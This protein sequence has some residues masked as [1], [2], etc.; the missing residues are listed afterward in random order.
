M[1]YYYFQIWLTLCSIIAERH[2]LSGAAR[3]DLH[4]LHVGPTARADGPQDIAY[5][6]Q[7]LLSRLDTPEYDRLHYCE[8]CGSVYQAIHVQRLREQAADSIA[9]CTFIALPNATRVSGRQPCGQPLESVSIGRPHGREETVIKPLKTISLMDVGLWLYRTCSFWSSDSELFTYIATRTA[10]PEG[11]LS[12]I[13]DGE[14]WNP[15]TEQYCT[16]SS[17]YYIYLHLAFDFVS[18]FAKDHRSNAETKEKKIG[19]LHFS[20]LNLP[21]HMRNTGRNICTAVV[22]EDEPPLTTNGV[23]AFIVKTLLSLYT[24]GMTVCTANNQS[25]FMRV[26]LYVMTADS[27]ARSKG[28]GCPHFCGEWPC[29]ICFAVGDII[30]S[31]NPGPPHRNYR[32]FRSFPER[33]H[34]AT[35]DVLEQVDD[36][37]TKTQHTNATS[38]EAKGVRWTPFL[39]LPYFHQKTSIAYD[40][41]HAWVEGLLKAKLRDLI[42]IYGDA[43]VASASAFVDRVKY[44]SG[45]PSKIRSALPRN[46]LE[47][48]DYAKAHEIL[49]FVNFLSEDCFKPLV[50][51]R[52]LV[53][54]T[55]LV[56]CSRFI[57]GYRVRKAD[58]PLYDAVYRTAMVLFQ[59]EDPA[60]ITLKSNAH[61]S[62][63]L[64]DAIRLFGPS[65]TVWCFFNERLM[66]RVRELNFSS[67]RNGLAVTVSNAFR[68]SMFS[69]S[70]LRYACAKDSGCR[71]APG[72][73]AKAQDLLSDIADRGPWDAP[74]VLQDAIYTASRFNYCRRTVGLQSEDVEHPLAAPVLDGRPSALF[75]V[76][77]PSG[78]HAPGTWQSKLASFLAD[79]NMLDTVA[80]TARCYQTAKFG[81]AGGMPLKAPSNTWNLSSSARDPN[82]C[83]ADAPVNGSVVEVFFPVKSAGGDGQVEPRAYYGQVLAFAEFSFT[84]TAD[85]LRLAFIKWRKPV[86]SPAALAGR[87]TSKLVSKETGRMLPPGQTS[88]KW[89]SPVVQ[90]VSATQC[91][92]TDEW[93]PMNRIASTVALLQLYNASGQPVNSKRV[94]RIPFA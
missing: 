29:F 52:H 81:P 5:E 7:A 55:M 46:M 35:L 8:T 26:V 17:A 32:D 50:S 48:I 11:L 45:L 78:G 93:I 53:C 6:H 4:V 2:H 65:F 70:I 61:F 9:K 62:T 1:H 94:I 68:Q 69:L 66:G 25:K 60:E 92:A 27:P 83:R 91:Y 36:A 90:L 39:Q 3:R 63:H 82:N 59:Q 56:E 42:A 37:T 89:T 15:F 77:D 86:K 34:A 80:R 67:S 28:F 73:L 57:A 84:G 31:V 12:D 40:P 19:L 10:P 72:I 71:I 87:L 51:P 75:N 20:I 16:D 79:N 54:W 85:K 74:S 49:T 23:T 13:Y 88:V 14:R 43:F 64:F 21:P 76:P 33:S 47:K 58:I 30:P 38:K 22:M 18:P 24:E 41:M 44:T